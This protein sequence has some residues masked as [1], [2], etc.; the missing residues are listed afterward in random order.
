MEFYPTIEMIGDYFRKSLQES[1]FLLFCNII[2]VIHEDDTPVYNA[3]GRALIE[4]QKLKL[5][6]EKE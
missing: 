4:E 2:I 3:P 6:K 5:K 1:Q